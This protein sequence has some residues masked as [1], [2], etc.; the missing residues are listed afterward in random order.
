VPIATTSYASL[1]TG[2]TESRCLSLASFDTISEFAAV[3][4]QRCPPSL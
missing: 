1:P 4:M 2:P 3:S